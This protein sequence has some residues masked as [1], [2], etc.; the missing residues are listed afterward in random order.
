[1]RGAVLRGTSP[2]LVP[3]NIDSCRTPIGEGGMPWTLKRELAATR[4]GP[5]GSALAVVMLAVGTRVE[6]GERIG[7]LSVADEPVVELSVGTDSGERVVYH[8]GE[9]PLWQAIRG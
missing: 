6:V 9:A 7:S 5:D 1:M 3:T 8:A 4:I 2:A